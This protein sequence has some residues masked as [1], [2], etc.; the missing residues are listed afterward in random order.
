MLIALDIEIDTQTE[1]GEI[2]ELTDYDATKYVKCPLKS[3][4]DSNSYFPNV[5][6]FQHLTGMA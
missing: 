3:H 4:A 1:E 5:D 6:I 2:H